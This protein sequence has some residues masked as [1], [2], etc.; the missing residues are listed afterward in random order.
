VAVDPERGRIYV[1]SNPIG[2]ARIVMVDPSTGEQTF[3]N[4]GYGSPL[5]FPPPGGGATSGQGSES[6]DRASSSSPRS[7]TRSRACSR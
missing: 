5:T 4:N 1:V 7:A 6:P 2:G 3:L